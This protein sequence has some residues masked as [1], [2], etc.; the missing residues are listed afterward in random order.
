MF[1]SINRLT[2]KPGHEATLESRFAARGGLEASPGFVSFQLLKRTWRPHHEGPE[3]EIEYLALTTWQTQ[4]DFFA[5]VDSPAFKAAHSGPK[6]DI[7]A[8]PAEPAGYTE[9][10]R[11]NPAN[12]EC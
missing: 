10:V 3:S 7:W 11:R 6:L 12:P 4:A 8:G 5:W 1:V 2:L 9:R